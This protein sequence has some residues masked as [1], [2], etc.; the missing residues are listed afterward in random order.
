[1]IERKDID[2]GSII[3]R[4]MF[5]SSKERVEFWYAANKVDYSYSQRSDSYMNTS[6]R[7]LVHHF[8]PFEF[9]ETS[10]WKRVEQ[11][12]DHPIG[13]V[14]AYINLSDSATLN[15]PHCDTSM[16]ELSILLCLNIDWHRSWGGYTV[17]FDDPTASSIRHCVC[18]EPG[19]AIFFNG[20]IFHYALPPVIFAPY[21]RFMLAIKT[22]WMENEI[23]TEKEEI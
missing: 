2:G 14:E 12:V 15:Y 1:M 13:C 20:S 16:N 5:P 19:K 4:K 21:S 6:Q 17:F 11:E 3:E 8:D 7:R 10:F 9:V 18:P 22:K 23:E